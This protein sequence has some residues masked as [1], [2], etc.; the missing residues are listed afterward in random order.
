MQIIIEKSIPGSLRDI[1]TSRVETVRDIFPRWC[2]KLVVEYNHHDSDIL[3]CEVQYEYRTF[4]LNIHP[5]FFEDED[6]LGSLIHEIGHGLVK[7]LVAFGEKM[8]EHF[9]SDDATSKFLL[10]NFTYL[11][12]QIA[13]DIAL[14]EK[15]LRRSQTLRK[16]SEADETRGCNTQA[17]ARRGKGR[18]PSKS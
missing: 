10:E 15:A 4:V 14:F 2:A 12:E 13:E 5:A 8:I 11:E 7:P 1:V 17:N 16:L 3:S 18:I 6:W 9:I